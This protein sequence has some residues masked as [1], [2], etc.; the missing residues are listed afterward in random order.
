LISIAFAIASLV[1]VVYVGFLIA[2]WIDPDFVFD[3]WLARISIM[4]LLG[5][6]AVAWILSVYVLLTH[7]LQIWPV[8]A[9]I[10]IGTFFARQHFKRAFRPATA[11]KAPQCRFSI[12]SL[13]CGVVIIVALLCVVFRIPAGMGYDAYA[14]WAFK[15]KAFFASG[16]ISFLLDPS[17]RSVGSS[18]IPWPYCVHADYPLMLPIYGW[19]VY[20]HLGHVSEHWMQAINVFFYVNLITLFYFCARREAS[21]AIALIGLCILVAS[22]P[23]ILYSTVV[24]SDIILSAY[25]LTSGYFLYRTMNENKPSDA[26]MLCL[27]SGSMVMVK[28]EALAWM[29]V[30][31][32]IYAV[33]NF[34]SQ[35]NR[36]TGFLLLAMIVGYL[37]WWII[38]HSAKLD[39]ATLREDSFNPISQS[40]RI[41]LPRGRDLCVAIARQLFGIGPQYPAWGLGWILI[42]GSLFRA[43]STKLK[44]L[45]AFGLLGL[46]QFCIYMLL[47]M[48]ISNFWFW[49]TTFLDRALVHVY[50]GLL[51]YA[52]ITSFPQ[53]EKS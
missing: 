38:K 13:I 5:A 36:R 47:F 10:V 25:F 6:G 31:L 50:P 20:A 51:L 7:R 33:V 32:L 16:D 18:S 39:A 1:A 42:L 49:V 12:L 14:F 46:S 44:G 37:P 52:L 24:Y 27:L 26:R 11:S 8:Y 9:F 40:I 30:T 48:Q 28:N 15:A 17:N 29:V 4:H 43:R 45:N 23:L 34:K 41:L 53:Q 3:N 19:W 21:P 2:G 22:R 35:Q